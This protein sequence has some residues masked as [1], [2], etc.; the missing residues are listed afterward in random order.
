M[1]MIKMVDTDGS[2]MIDKDEVQRFM[3]MK[4]V[5]G[6]VRHGVSWGACGLCTK[7]HLVTAVHNLTTLATAV[8]LQ[9]VVTMCAYNV[10]LQCV[11]QL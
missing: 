5:E 9:C 11:V 6:K 10:R 7:S 3:K 2:G 4:R 1:R 8:W